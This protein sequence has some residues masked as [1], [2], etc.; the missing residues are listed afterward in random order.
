MD[1][2]SFLSKI[3]GFIIIL[4]IIFFIVLV[5]IKK[6]TDKYKTYLINKYLKTKNQ[7]DGKKALLFLRKESINYNLEEIKNL[8]K[9]GV[10]INLPN[11]K[12]LSALVEASIKGDYDMAKTLLEIGADKSTLPKDMA[13]IFAS[14][15]GNFNEA[16]SLIK[17]GAN[18]NFKILYT[19]KTSLIFACEKFNYAMIKLLIENGADVNISYNILGDYNLGS[20]PILNMTALI[21]ICKD[22]EHNNLDIAKL[23]LENGANVNA[24][25]SLGKTALSLTKYRNSEMAELLK[26]YGAKE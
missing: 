8:V 26:S 10:D 1:K 3:W 15:N 23:L 9:H 22:R 17:N 21:A 7:K 6:I 13:L 19:K 24:K 5:I 16:E 14:E 12:G 25:N 20:L 11:K 2:F 18:V 4:A